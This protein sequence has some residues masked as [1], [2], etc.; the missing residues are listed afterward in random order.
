MEYVT[1][2]AVSQDYSYG[3]QQIYTCSKQAFKH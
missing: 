3:V 2:L 1:L